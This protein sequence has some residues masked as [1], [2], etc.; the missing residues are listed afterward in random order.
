MEVITPD[1]LVGESG[2]VPQATT[3]EI[4]KVTD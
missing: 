3:N 1:M 2:V 4:Q